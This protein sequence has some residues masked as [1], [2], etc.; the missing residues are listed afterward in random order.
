M[1]FSFDY[2]LSSLSVILSNYRLRYPV[3]IA[4]SFS[5]IIFDFIL[6][7]STSIADSS[8]QLVS[9]GLKFCVKYHPSPEKIKK[10][11]RS[12][13]NRIRLFLKQLLQL[14]GNGISNL[15][16]LRFSTDITCA[17]TSFS[18]IPNCIFDEACFGGTLKRILE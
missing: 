16:G 1:A 4:P 3:N 13:T 18:D 9:F 8:S 15:S 12:I 10:K 2:R 6:R 14:G 7:S 5:V 11:D 17:N